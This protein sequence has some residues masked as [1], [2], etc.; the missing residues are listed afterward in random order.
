[1]EDI[2]LVIDSNIV[3]HCHVPG[4]EEM[5]PLLLLSSF[6]VFDICYP[7]GY[8]NF[9]SLL[10]H[11]LFDMPLSSTVNQSVKHLLS[12]CDHHLIQ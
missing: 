11:I 3:T 12:S 8:Y 7:R 6:F 10:E 4:T 2:M 1:M 9:Y 5:L